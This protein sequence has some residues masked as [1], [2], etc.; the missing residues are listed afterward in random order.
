MS[1]PI[2]L[3]PRLEDLPLR[4]EPVSPSAAPVANSMG[5][6]IDIPL[7]PASE[8]EVIA[9]LGRAFALVCAR[10]EGRG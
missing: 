1:E 9:A 4:A 5:Q 7:V 8:D 10:A 3:S 2:T 6:S